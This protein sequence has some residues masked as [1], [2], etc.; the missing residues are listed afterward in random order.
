MKTKE[1][2][3]EEYTKY[4]SKPSYI[5]KTDFSAGWD[6]ATANHDQ[7]MVEYAEWVEKCAEYQTDGRWF[8]I[9]FGATYTTVE[10][11][12]KFRKSK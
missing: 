6:A 2:A 4:K 5:S 10:L 1:E 9:Q 3:F 8:V 7:E 11:L 12:T